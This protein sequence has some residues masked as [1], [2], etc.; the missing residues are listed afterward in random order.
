[1]K[2]DIGKIQMSRKTILKWTLAF[3]IMAG[4]SSC[5]EKAESTNEVVENKEVIR[6]FNFQD[7]EEFTAYQ[8]LNLDESYPNLLDP[9]ISKSD[10]NA[11][12][13]SWSDFHQ[14]I[15]TFL[16]DNEFT[17]GVEDKS[18]SIVQKIY[19]EPNGRI[20]YY[21]FRVLNENV[22]NEKLGQFANLIAEFAE[23]NRID[24]QTDT[25]FAQCG[26]TKYMNE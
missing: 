24:F 14:R 9:Q 10:H 25:S 2:L 11:V 16:S 1:M 3:C 15:G 23:T 19:F 12:I 8:S 6:V 21:F 22:T 7:K 18:I 5:K 4:V 26:K 20:K 13:E 17:W